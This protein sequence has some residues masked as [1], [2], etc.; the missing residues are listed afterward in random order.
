MVR[1]TLLNVAV[2]T[3][4]LAGAEA[5][6]C[7]P[8]TTAVTS[9]AVTTTTLAATTTTAVPGCVETQLLVNPGF[10]DTVG[11]YAPWTGDAVLIQRDPQAGTQ[12]VAFIYN[13][14]QSQGRE[15]IKQTLTNLNGDYEFSY[16]YR[17]VVARIGMTTACGLQVK[18][19]EDTTVPSNI[20][21]VAGDWTS[22]S[23]SWSTAGHN[24]E[25]ADVELVMTC[26]GDWD[27][28]QIFLDSFAFTSV[29]S[30]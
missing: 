9:A 29:C 21:L 30:A 19:G 23:V 11:G 24:V 27:T 6:L 5:G 13:A 14:G 26:R 18:I 4:F 17:V 20:E 28:I 3:T 1:F 10:D 25:Q 2:I 7:R 8:S 15:S 16:Y 22:G 12:A